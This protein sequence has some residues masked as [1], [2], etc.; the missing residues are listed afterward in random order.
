MSIY[1]HA[2]KY[3]DRG[4]IKDWKKNVW[5]KKVKWITPQV[6]KKGLMPLIFSVHALRFLISGTSQ[7]Y[8]VYSLSLILFLLR[9]KINLIAWFSQC[10]VIKSVILTWIT[11]NKIQGYMQIQPK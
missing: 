2:L 7:K 9:N 10:H 4:L 5:N 3:T 1:S 6:F 11:Y 8:I